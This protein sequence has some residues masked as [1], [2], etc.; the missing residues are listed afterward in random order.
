MHDR[1][2]PDDQLEQ[3][4]QLWEQRIARGEQRI[5]Q[6]PAAERPREKL[7]ARGPDALSDLELMAI[8]LGSGTQSC[9]VFSL[10]ARILEV[11]NHTGSKP[12]VNEL[13]KIAGIGPSKAATVAAAIEFARRRFH[14]RDR[15]IS[16]TTDVLPFIRHISTSKQEHFVC[17][18][19]NGANEVLENRIVTI[20]LV[21]RTYVHPREVF[22]DPLIDRATAVIIGHNHPSGDVTPSED[23]KQITQYL[24]A[25]GKILGIELLDHIIF[26]QQDHY[27]SLENGEL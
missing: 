3:L 21:D 18:S 6:M 26:T 7:L 27:S 12:E 22:A 1:T 24:K 8:L 23:D 9:D 10:S 16:K 19:L 11:L 25:A 13:R 15:K 5:A 4:Q 2:P 20:G 14:P 17:I